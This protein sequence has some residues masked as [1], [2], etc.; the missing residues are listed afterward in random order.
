MFER[1]IRHIQ[2]YREIAS[3]FSRNGF[4][5]LVEELGLQ[6]ILSLPKRLLKKNHEV[7][8]KTTGERV[9][10]FLEQLG[11]TFVKLGQIASTRPDVIPADMIQEISKLQDRVSPF[12]TDEVKTIIEQELGFE[13]DELFSEFHEEP[14]GAASIGQV[15]YAVLKTGEQVA[16]KVQRP[17]VEKMIHTDLE[18]LEELAAL[19]EHR[20]RWAEKYQVKAIVEEFSKAI[21][22]ELDYTIEAKNAAKIARQFENNQKIRIPSVYK[23]FSTKKVLTTEYFEGTKISEHEELRNKG[24]HLGRVANQITHAIFHQVLIEGFFHGDPHPGNILV[25]EEEVIVFIDFGMVGRLTY[26]MKIQLANLVIAM[27]RQSSDGVIKAINQMGLVPEDVNM[28]LLR[29]DIEE[30]KEKYYDVPLSEVHLG[31]AVNDLMEIAHEHRIRIPADLSLL[32]KTFLTLEGM[33][34]KLDP[35]FSIMKAA[36]PFGRQLIKERLHPKRMAERMITHVGEYGEIILEFP[37][38]MKEITALLKKEKIPLEISIPKV[39]LFLTKLDRISNRLSFSIVL[40]SFSIIMV[41]LIIGSSLRGQTSVLWNIPAVEIGF[42]VALL[43]FL[44]LL[45]SIFKS[46]RF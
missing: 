9:R 43:M 11:P 35:D 19:A 29:L 42:G 23:E 31:E 4:G 8:A 16:V 7:H 27:M 18:I 28:R 41:G 1:R 24:Y 32:G 40:L 30:L 38:Q 10:L 13:I 21:L 15:H 26:D 20:L 33:V 5:F 12:P 45:Y 22:A 25:L 34:E 37:K 36:E 44:W 46:G 14:L 2:R 39:E 17:G 3:A 6:D